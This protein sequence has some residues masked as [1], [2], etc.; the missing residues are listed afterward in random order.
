MRW[1]RV[2]S[3]MT[4][5]YQS[6][7]KNKDTCEAIKRWQQ[8]FYLGVFEPS[9]ENISLACGDVKQPPEKLNTKRLYPEDRLS[10]YRNSILGGITNG[11]MGIYP[12]CTRLVGDTFF[13]HMVSGYL[14]EYPS[15]SPDVGDYGEFLADYLDI[16]LEKI[17]QLDGLKYLPDVARLEWLWHKAF[18]AVEIVFE[19]EGENNNELRPLTE[20]ANVSPEDQGSIL[21]QLR[22]S[23]GLLSTTYAVDKIWQINQKHLE[24]PQ[25]E[26]ELTEVN[27]QFVIWRNADFSMHID[28]IVLA[29][30]EIFL[31]D[32]QQELS[33]ANIA[34]KEYASPVEVLLPHYLQSGLIVGFRLT[35]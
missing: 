23:L 15:S 31:A 11:L 6:K 30:G 29:G 18:N 16:F 33:F 21:F 3:L 32:I 8:D 25:S 34:A 13:T 24:D 5:K 17:N 26:F 19:S 9:R 4:D 27:R 28:P 14:K 1:L 20:L 2:C 35:K 7:D 10:I 12:V 22:P